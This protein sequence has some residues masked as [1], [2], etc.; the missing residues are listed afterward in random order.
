MFINSDRI[1]LSAKAKEFIVFGKGNT[2][3]ITDGRFTV[4]TKS[5]ME[6]HSEGD[7]VFRTDKDKNIVLAAS[8]GGNIL[9]GSENIAKASGSPN[10]NSDIQ[11][12]IMGEALVKVLEDLITAISQMQFATPSG[13][14][15]IGSLIV[16][17]FNTIKSSIKDKIL[18][19]RNWISKQ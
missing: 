4:D 15:P 6:V 14:T 3:I 19:N 9:I 1:I 8:K 7:I 11:H 5:G 12:M 10:E 13:P 17:Q 2:G 16:A 18:S